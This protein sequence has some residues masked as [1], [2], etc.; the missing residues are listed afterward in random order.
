MD[1]GNPDDG[2]VDKDFPPL[3]STI[4]LFTI[5][6]SKQFW[7]YDLISLQWED[8]ESEIDHILGALLRKKLS[9][10]WPNWMKDLKIWFLWINRNGN[11]CGWTNEI[12]ITL[13]GGFKS[14]RLY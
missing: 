1:F 11:N 10:T 12:K 5:L 9:L 13:S 2:L 4:S 3:S 8:Q 6:N 14:K 7:K